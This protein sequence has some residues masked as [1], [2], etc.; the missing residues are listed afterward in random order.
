[1]VY[2]SLSFISWVGFRLQ[3]P[4]YVSPATHPDDVAFRWE[5]PEKVD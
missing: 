1:M 3:P 5:N 2:E 4:E